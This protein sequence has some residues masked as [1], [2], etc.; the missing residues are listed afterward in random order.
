VGGEDWA[1][2]H[3]NSELMLVRTGL[4][5]SIESCTCKPMSSET[6]YS[7]V[8]FWLSALQ[9]LTMLKLQ[10]IQIGT[11]TS[12]QTVWIGSQARSSR[13]CSKE[14]V[15]RRDRFPFWSTPLP[16]QTCPA[17]LGGHSLPWRQ[18]FS[19]RPTENSSTAYV[20]YT[21]LH[22]MGPE[23]RVLSWASMKQ[24]A[25]QERRCLCDKVEGELR[26]VWP[27]LD[28]VLHLLRDTTMYARNTGMVEGAKRA[29]YGS[30][31]HIMHSSLF[32][33]SLCPSPCGTSYRLIAFAWIEGLMQGEAVT[34]NSKSEEFRTQMMVV[35]IYF[36]KTVRLTRLL[37][38]MASLYC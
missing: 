15:F 4:V 5:F 12:L 14:T 26:P 23:Q 38:P 10:G 8:T 31:R 37:L 6:R 16:G 33:C 30:R 35:K 20:Y 9:V 13:T 7:V 32:P 28:D 22:P 36:H 34:S 2:S 25:R 11:V 3:D 1:I 29:G 21:R 19:A 18:S 24:I 27:C 17:I